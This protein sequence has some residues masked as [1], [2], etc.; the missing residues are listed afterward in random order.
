MWRDSEAEY[1]R[2]VKAASRRR[3]EGV[4]PYTEEQLAETL[5]QVNELRACKMQ[6]DKCRGDLSGSAPAIVVDGDPF[7]SHDN[8]R[9]TD[10]EY[11]AQVEAA[12]PRA[13]QIPILSAARLAQL[14]GDPMGAL[15]TTTLTPVVRK[16]LEA[17]NTKL[18]VHRLS[19]TEHTSRRDFQDACGIPMFIADA[20][21]L[22]LFG[23]YADYGVTCKFV[24]P[25][26][27]LESYAF[28]GSNLSVRS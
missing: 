4:D 1:I 27:V 22:Y 26:W 18:R 14:S 20:E 5:R 10:D 6:P 9:R 7:G 8:D 23:V 17:V 2:Q 21:P 28:T 13:D 16:A 12:R 15:C 24:Q 19:E 3:D 11:R 25:G